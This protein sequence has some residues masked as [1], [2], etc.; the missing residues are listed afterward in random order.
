MQ[1]KC[2]NLSA[3]VLVIV[4]SSASV[5]AQ[6]DKVMLYPGPDVRLNGGSLKA[7]SAVMSGDKVET[8]TNGAQLTGHDLM[9]QV[10]PGTSLLYGDVL[11][12]SCGGLLVSS[13]WHPVQASDTLVS[14]L[15]GMAK[16]TLVNRGGKLTIS[17]Q[18]GTVTVSN[19]QT[20]TLSA[21][22]SI[23]RKSAECPVAGAATKTTKPSSAALGGNGKWIALA[24]AGGTAT[25][26]GVYFAERKPASPSAP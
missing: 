4:L 25:A 10:D 22:Q 17:V 19:E 14:P 21:G 2:R 15:G 1:G 23:E 24:A 13:A 26:V 9:L 12:L 5:F 6:A 20:T 7:S 11:L 3:W 18:S 8:G 16:F